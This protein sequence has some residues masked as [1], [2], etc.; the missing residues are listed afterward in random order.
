MIHEFMGDSRWNRFLGQPKKRFIADKL[1]YGIA[2]PSF[3]QLYATT[4]SMAK[5]CKRF[6]RAHTNILGHKHEVRGRA[7]VLGN[8]IRVRPGDLKA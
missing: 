2:D 5:E 1:L 8:V 7:D 3:L 4:L 6:R